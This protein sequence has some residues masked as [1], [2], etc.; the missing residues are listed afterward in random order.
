MHVEINTNMRHRSEQYLDNSRPTNCS[1]GTDRPT[2]FRRTY[3]CYSYNPCNILSLF[4][5]SF[6]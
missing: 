2:T 3:S 6:L 4:Y 1:N 5:L